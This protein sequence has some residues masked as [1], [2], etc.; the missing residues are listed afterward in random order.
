[1]RVDAE[2]GAGVGDVEVAHGELADA[3]E[4][5]ER[6][7]FDFFHAQAFGLVGQVGRFGVQNRIV[8]AAAQFKGDFAGNGFGDP[9]LGGFAQHEGLAVEP[10]ALVEQ[11]AEAQA[12]DAVLFDG[13]LVVD[14]GYQAFVG[15]VEQRHA[16]GFVDA[17]RFGFDDAV[18]DLVAH[19]QTVASAD[20][21]GLEE[22]LDGVGVFFAVQCNGHAFFK[23]HADFFG[24]DFDAFVPEGNAHD[25]FDDFDAAVEKFQIF[26]FMRRAEHI[27]IGG[28]GFLHR[29]FV[30]EAVG[31]QKFAHFVAAAEFVD[32]LLVEPGFVDFQRGI[33]QEAVAVETLDVVAFVGTAVAPNVDVVF[34]HGG[35]EHGAGNGAA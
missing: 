1:M 29:H 6:G 28:I 31:N 21:V 26:G 33:G 2:F 9:A 14:T 7:V 18:F 27:G 35:N 13:V 10:A 25:G 5:G 3:V 8:V 23:A 11:T 4:R 30:V 19:A 34:L 22:E 16:R 24:F 12:V 20:A 17:A 32:K 15:D